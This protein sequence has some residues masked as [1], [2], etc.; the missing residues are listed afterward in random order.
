M[1]GS[2][3]MRPCRNLKTVLTR[4][5]KGRLSIMKIYTTQN[6]PNSQYTRWTL[7]ADT[8]IDTDWEQKMFSAPGHIYMMSDTEPDL[9]YSFKITKDYIISTESK[10][11]S[12]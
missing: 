11:D 3:P 12:Q 8:K 10:T 9:F 6:D 7:L 4:L 5:N 1:Y 2:K